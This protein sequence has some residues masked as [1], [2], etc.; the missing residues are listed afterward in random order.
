MELEYSY[1]DGFKR[2][3]VALLILIIM[4][5]I[6]TKDYK[7]CFYCIIFWLIFSIFKA[8]SVFITIKKDKFIKDNGSKFEME[9]DK[10]IKNRKYRGIS[11]Y[12]DGKYYHSHSLHVNDAFYILEEYYKQIKEKNNNILNEFNLNVKSDNENIEIYT[13]NVEKLRTDLNN[14]ENENKKIKVDLYI[15]NEKYYLDIKSVNVDEV[16][17]LLYKNI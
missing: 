15:Y 5:Y 6:I 8:I 2:F 14:L 11:V 9:I 1:K 7:F 3:F 13:K 12:F 10:C 4:S 16:N 17:N